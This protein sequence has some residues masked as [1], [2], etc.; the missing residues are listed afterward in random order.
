MA[1]KAVIDRQRAARTVASAAYTYS[2]D[3]ASRV[4]ETLSRYAKPGEQVPD[5]QLLVKL[6]GRMIA[7]ENEA[8]GRADAAHELEL[9]DDTEPRKLRDEAAEKLRRILTDLRTAVEMACGTAGLPRLLLT[10]VI[11]NDPSTL[12]VL[13]RSVLT[14]LRDESIKLPAPRRR[15]LSLDREAFAEELAAELPAL[16]KALAAVAREAREAEATLRA[17]RLAME[18]NDRA[19]GRGAAFLSATFTLAGLDDIANKTKPSTSH[20]GQTHEADAG[21]MSSDVETDAP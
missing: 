11:P 17:K 6:V 19:F 3:A 9:A 4:K 5:I 8:L 16:D 2:A 21:T 1:S 13:A 7:S 14:H 12:S 15:G 20:P 10:D 18:T